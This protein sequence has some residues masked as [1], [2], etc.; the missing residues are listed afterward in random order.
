MANP[1]EDSL[2][3]PNPNENSTKVFEKKQKRERKLNESP[4]Q[5]INNI[6]YSD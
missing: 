4:I 6:C 1:N 5:L 2:H 3:A